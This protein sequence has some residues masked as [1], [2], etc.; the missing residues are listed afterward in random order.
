[1]PVLLYGI[2]QSV[3]AVLCVDHSTVKPGQRMM[4]RSWERNMQACIA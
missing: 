3:R 4:Y 1:M 2:L